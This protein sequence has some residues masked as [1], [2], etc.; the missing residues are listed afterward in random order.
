MD[1]PQAL[2]TDSHGNYPLPNKLSVNKL[3]VKF[4]KCLALTDC[5]N[6]L[7]DIFIMNILLFVIWRD[8]Y[9]SCDQF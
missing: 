2:V 6:H 1:L 7:I 3:L 5:D 4:N 9:I 8:K